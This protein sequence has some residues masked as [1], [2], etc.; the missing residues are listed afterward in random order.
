MISF[1][2]GIRFSNGSDGSFSLPH[3]T[4]RGPQEG[5][6]SL[7]PAYRTRGLAVFALKLVQISHDFPNAGPKAAQLV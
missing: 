5:S 6:R 1:D 7:I 4:R 2:V 3:A